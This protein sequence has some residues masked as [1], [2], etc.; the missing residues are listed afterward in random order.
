MLDKNSESQV[1]V[2][3]IEEP[4]PG[5][6]IAF[7]LEKIGLIAVKAP[8]VSVIILLVLIGL[9]LKIREVARRHAHS[10]DDTDSAP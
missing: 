3:A 2:E 6:S 5:T 9:G 8:I 4:Q 10:S 7:G 1:H